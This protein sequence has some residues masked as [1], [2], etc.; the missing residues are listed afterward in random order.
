[1]V[2]PVFLFREAAWDGVNVPEVKE[3][4]AKVGFATVVDQL[5]EQEGMDRYLRDEA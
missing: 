4:T 1:V 3:S 2:L 5:G